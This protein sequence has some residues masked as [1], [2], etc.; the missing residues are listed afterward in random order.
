MSVPGEFVCVSNRAVWIGNSNNFMCNPCYG[1]V[2]QTAAVSDCARVTR[3][4][5]LPG[6][7]LLLR[8]GVKRSLKLSAGL[9]TTRTDCFETAEGTCTEGQGIAHD[10]CR[11]LGWFI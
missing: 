9:E 3:C 6:R 2:M 4:Q 1:H 10:R 11:P 5:V 7:L 8:K